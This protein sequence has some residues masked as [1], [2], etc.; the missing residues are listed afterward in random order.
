MTGSGRS[1]PSGLPS[2]RA[3][4]KSAEGVFAGQAFRAEGGRPPAFAHIP[5]TIL[6]RVERALE[7]KPVVGRGSRIGEGHKERVSQIEVILWTHGERAAPGGFARGEGD[8]APET[9]GAVH[10][11][12][13]EQFA[14]RLVGEFALGLE[15]PELERE[16]VLDGEIFRAVEE[17]AEVEQTP[18]GPRLPVRRIEHALGQDKVVRVGL[19]PTA[20]VTDRTK[21]L[22]TAQLLVVDRITQVELAG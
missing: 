1:V 18:L 16:H 14:Q 21:H 17:E 10:R 2:R 6:R 11:V 20:A 5:K 13:E 22:D 4:V 12:V 3:I 8:I 7:H 9:F 15:P 19:L